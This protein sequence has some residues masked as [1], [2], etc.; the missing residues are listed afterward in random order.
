MAEAKVILSGAVYRVGR[1]RLCVDFERPTAAGLAVSV[2]HHAHM[3]RDQGERAGRWLAAVDAIQKKRR[4]RSADVARE[5]ARGV[6][7]DLP[8]DAGSESHRPPGAFVFIQVAPRAR[9]RQRW[10]V[11]L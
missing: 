6:A 10:R 8:H 5:S 3:R 4:L 1:G 9:G 7:G 2:E 11:Q